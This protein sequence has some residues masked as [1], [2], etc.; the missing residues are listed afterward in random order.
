MMPRHAHQRGDDDGEHRGT[1]QSEHGLHRLDVSVIGVKHGQNPEQQ[2]GRKNKQDRR[3]NRPAQPLHFPSRING[4][5]VRL[6]SG[7]HQAEVE[8]AGEFIRP[9][10]LPSLY[11]FLPQHGDLP[12]RTAETDQ[13]QPGKEADHLFQ[14]GFYLAGLVHLFILAGRT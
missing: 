7:E 4:Q 11:E 9:Q 3:G 12:G 5:L 2:R 13:S 1:D 8:A 14:A 6:R 10:P